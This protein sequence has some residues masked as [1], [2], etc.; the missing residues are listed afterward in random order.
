MIEE[1]VGEVLRHL[2]TI[3]GRLAL[4]VVGDTSRAREAVSLGV[5][6]AYLRARGE[7]DDAILI[8]V[9]AHPEIF[10]LWA[11]RAQAAPRARCDLMRIRFQRGR[12][13]V[14]FIEV[15]S[16]AAAGHSEELAHR[17]VD[18]IEAT[19]QVM[20]DLFFRRDPRRLDH[21]LQRSRLATVLRFY[22]QRA[23]R[24]NLIS[25]E[26]RREEL[27]A[28]IARLEGGIPDA[29]GAARFRRESRCSA[30]ASAAPSR[31]FD[32]AHHGSRR[33]RSRH[34]HRGTCRRVRRTSRDAARG[35][36]VWRARDPRNGRRRA[37]T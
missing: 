22:L 15:K 2:K 36:F 3:S 23:W 10:G 27:E 28:A 4:R 19:E 6:A 30:G 34:G 32:P 9:D 33:H 13:A 37:G 5:V 24:H 26:D 25:S 18:Q 8:P 17:I 31:Q 16:R 29:R 35:R 1:S 21:V 20:R 7:L 11:R 14:T 12:L